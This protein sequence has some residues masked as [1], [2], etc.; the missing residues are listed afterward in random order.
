MFQH[1]ILKSIFQKYTLRY[2]L[3]HSSLTHFSYFYRFSTCR[4]FL[5]ES[6]S[7]ENWV[8]TWNSQEQFSDLYFS[9]MYSLTH[10]SLTFW[11]LIKYWVHVCLGVLTRVLDQGCFHPNGGVGA[12][13]TKP[14]S[15]QWGLGCRAACVR[16]PHALAALND[17]W[18]WQPSRYGTEIMNLRVK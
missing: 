14:I 12:W 17:V 8:W 15:L 7:V 4:I 16:K 18:L 10:H 5:H 1:E 3:T 11:V 9:N 13:G 2:V 6:V